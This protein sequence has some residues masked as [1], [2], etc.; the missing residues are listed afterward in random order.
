MRIGLIAGEYPP[1]Q[2]GV[3]AYTRIL[4][5][6]YADMGHDV[7]VFADHRAAE[8]HTKI[9]MTNTVTR[10]TRRVNRQIG[11]WARTN[12]LDIVNLQFETAAFNMSIWVHLLAGFVRP[13]P[14]VTTF[15]DLLVPYLFPK[16]GRVRKWS[17]DHLAR[18]SAGVVATNHGDYRQLRHLPRVTLIPI[19]SNI[20]TQL[21]PDYDRE[22][23]RLRAGA[24]QD[25]FL[26]AFFGFMNRSKG[27]EILLE[28]LA[29]LRESGYPIRL[30]IIGGRTG[31]SDAANQAY[32]NEVDG[33]I[34]KLAVGQWITRTGFVTD[35]EVSAF[36]TSS[37]AVV[38]PFRDGASYR[39]GTLMAAINHGTA[40]VTTQPKASIP[41]F[42][43]GE[44][45]LLVRTHVLDDN[46][47]PF[48]HTFPK[49]IRLYRDPELRAKL[50]AGSTELAKEFEW[51]TIAKDNITFFE[52]VLEH[53]G[54][55]R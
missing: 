1:M 28:D 21:P 50:R 53:K 32:A 11:R 7:F 12:Q 46:C 36:L 31:T 43:D 41:M 42:K 14:L 4:A 16:A 25:D 22:A 9:Q 13:A 39:R 30:V 23:F 26:I 6:Q 15:H 48:Q 10:W 17:V 47:P 52:M 19:G 29:T 33:L 40:I 3:G 27:I 45:M 38:L 49:I 54:Q 37:D 35:E 51:E 8:D 24:Q 2:G 44:N 18:K 34:E 5:R 55:S 20:P